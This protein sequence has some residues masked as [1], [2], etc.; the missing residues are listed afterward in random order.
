MNRVLEL[1]AFLH[2]YGWDSALQIPFAADFSPRRYARLQHPDG[3][4][5]VLMDADIDQKTPQFIALAKIVRDLGL[6][7]PD[8]YAAD[9]PRGL[10]LMED[11][12]SQ[13]CGALLDAGADPRPIYE[14]ATKVLV[15]LHRN[16][17][18]QKSDLALPVFN[19]AL[20]TEQVE[21]FLETCPHEVSTA[22]RDDFRAAW[23][24][25][26]QPLDAMPQSLMLRDFMPDNL[27]DL[28]DRVGAQ[29]LGILDF[30]DAGIGPIAYDL[31]SLCETVRRDGGDR[32]ADE[33]IESYHR[34]AQPMLSLADLHRACAILSAQRHMRVLGIVTRLITRGHPE[35]RAY[36]PRVA[37]RLTDLLQHPSLHPVQEWVRIY[38]VFA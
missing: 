24:A 11:F 38:Q 28:S 36:L 1:T 3:R 12:G 23:G 5:A 2:R 35:K 17:V 33:V 18:Q 31:A 29:S 9:P 4:Q 15:Q 22:M 25:V 27:M 32:M 37:R 19:A 21:L 13:N 6:S 20:F 30:Q 26:L 7:A 10:V 8:I 16:F 34:Q 14:R